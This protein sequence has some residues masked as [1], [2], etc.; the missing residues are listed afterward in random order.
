M[1]NMNYIGDSII[2]PISF[3]LIS[4]NVVELKG[5]FPIFTAGFTLSRPNHD[6]KWDYS[7]FTTVY[8]KVD[9]GVRFSNDGSVYV[10]KGSISADEFP[11][12]TGEE[13][14]APE[15]SGE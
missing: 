5:D 10:E 3:K 8:Q 15:G 9:G 11:Y 2:Y 12:I 6:D 13:Y 4:D 7:A 1:L 14:V